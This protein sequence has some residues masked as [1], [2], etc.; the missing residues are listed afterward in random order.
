MIV[1][2]DCRCMHN[3]QL[4]DNQLWLIK[5]NFLIMILKLLGDGN[6]YCRMKDDER[7]RRK[8]KPIFKDCGQIFAEIFIYE[9]GKFQRILNTEDIWALQY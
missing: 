5:K 2:S 9:L 6:Q 3:N 1:E 7:V 8:N 4:S